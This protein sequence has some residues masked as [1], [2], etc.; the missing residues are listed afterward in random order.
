MACSAYLG[1]T[2][3]RMIAYIHVHCTYRMVGLLFTLP[4]GKDMDQSLS[5]YFKQ[6]TQ[7]STSVG[8]YDTNTIAYVAAGS[9]CI[10]VHVYTSMCMVWML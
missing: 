6:N 3:I 5:Y 9:T 2:S 10:C 1:V 4:A 7:M 8:R